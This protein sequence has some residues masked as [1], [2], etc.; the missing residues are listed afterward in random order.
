[1]MQD[2]YHMEPSWIFYVKV[3]TIDQ[4]QQNQFCI[5]TMTA[6]GIEMLPVNYDVMFS[7]C[8]M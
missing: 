7:I 1:M 8:F 4:L 6:L 3:G 5:F 2:M